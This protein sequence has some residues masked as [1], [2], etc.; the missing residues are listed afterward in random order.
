M[1]N[2][3]DQFMGIGI[4]VVL[5]VVALIDFIGRYK[6]ASPDKALIVSGSFLGKNTH[7]DKATGN[8]MKVV[9][10]GGTFV[11]GISDSQGAIALVEQ[12]GKSVRRLSTRRK[13]FLSQLTE[14]L[15]LRSV[16]QL[17]K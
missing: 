4:L 3:L 9:R 16:P 11:I 7:I 15:S 1:T 13:G 12:I 17:K 14:Q 8:T 6:T 10:G 2:F 5:L